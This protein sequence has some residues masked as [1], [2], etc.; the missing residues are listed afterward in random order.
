MSFADAWRRP[1]SAATKAVALVVGL[2]LG[3]GVVGCSTSGNATPAPTRNLVVGA[4][5]EP[6]SMDAW[7]V[8]GASIPQVLLYN[9]YETLVKVDA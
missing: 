7:H 1:R 5:F 3:F 8:V 2:T 4:T 9:V 6:S